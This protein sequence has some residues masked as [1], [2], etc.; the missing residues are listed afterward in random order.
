L[1][2][3]TARRAGFGLAALHPAVPRRRFTTAIRAL[4]THRRRT[5][6]VDTA[7]DDRALRLLAAT[8]EGTGTPASRAFAADRITGKNRLATDLLP[9]QAQAAA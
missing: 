4:A 6:A 7:V 5:I 1:V 8:R 3:R 2:I 9:N